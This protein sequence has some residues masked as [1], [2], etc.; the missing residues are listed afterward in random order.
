M[1]SQNIFAREF[2][3]LIPDGIGGVY[4]NK[5]CNGIVQLLQ[6]LFFFSVHFPCR[7]QYSPRCYLNDL[8]TNHIYFL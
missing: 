5:F 2:S 4:C 6:K 8:T 7:K 1:I 3:Q